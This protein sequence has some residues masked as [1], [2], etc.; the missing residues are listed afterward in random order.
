MQNLMKDYESAK[1]ALYDHVGFMEDW[2]VYAIQDNT[3]MFW[4]ENGKRVKFA[5]TMQKFNSDGYFY[6]YSIYTQRFYG[7]WVYRGEDLTLIITDTH[8]D[9]NKFFSVF[10]NGKEVK[11]G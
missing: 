5:E 11:S 3:D 9:G 7:R 4:N 8:T 2:V 6:E 1:Q 10:A